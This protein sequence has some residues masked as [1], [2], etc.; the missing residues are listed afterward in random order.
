[1]GPAPAK[2][3]RDMFADGPVDY[4]SHKVSGVPGTV[5]GLALAHSKLGSL[6]WKDL[7][8]PAVKLAEGFT[9]D[10]A[11]ARRLNSTVGNNRT[12][13]AEFIRVYGKNGAKTERG[14]AGE[15]LNLAALARTIRTIME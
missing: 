7:V 2:A 3:P 12:T 11:L 5:R 14:A 1:G 15:V 10:A 4:H 8:A 6:P 9:I 13:N